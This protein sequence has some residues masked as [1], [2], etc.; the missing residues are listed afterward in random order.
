VNTLLLIL[1]ALAVC[2]AARAA[3]WSWQ[4]AAQWRVDHQSNR[5]LSVTQ[6]QASEA[7]WLTLDAAVQRATEDVQLSLQPH[8]ELQRFAQDSVLDA[9]NESLQVSGKR[10]WEYSQLTAS[11]QWS[12]L[13]TL[14]SELAETG[15]VNVNTRQ[16]MRSAQ[17]GWAFSPTPQSQL[18][19]QLV[20][21]N[22]DY[23]DGLRFGLVGYRYFTASVGVTRQISSYT[24][25]TVG[26]LGSH[27]TDPILEITSRDVGV[28]L[29]RVGRRRR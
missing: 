17:A 19:T 18:Q 25:W 9:E 5:L 1:F 24:S 6:P 7:G 11:A 10:L 20:F 27:V 8:F 29:L 3:D 2:T 12:R 4:P 23:P 26:A 14:T 13:S 21:S 22:V 28:Q 16:E 15:I